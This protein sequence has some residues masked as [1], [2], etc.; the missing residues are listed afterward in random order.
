[1]ISM[2]DYALLVRSLGIIEGAASC[3]S[4]EAA[5]NVV[6]GELDI[7]DPILEKLEKEL[8]GNEQG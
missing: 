7:I 6:I 1:M 4:D 5:K 3:A 2:Y 8:F